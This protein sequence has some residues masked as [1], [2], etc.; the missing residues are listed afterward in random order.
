M[1][2]LTEIIQKRFDGFLHTNSLWKNNTFYGLKQFHLKQKYIKFN[3][4]INEKLRL[5]KYVERFVSYQLEQDNSIEIIAENVQIQKEKRTLGEI[6][7]ILL[8]HKKPIHLEIVYKFYLY[9]DSIGITEVDHFIGPNRKDTLLEKLQKLKTKQLPLLF[10]KACE[11]YLESLAIDSSLITQEVY[12]KAQIFIPF[13]KKHLKLK[14]L[15]G[16]CISGFYIHQKELTLFVDCKFYIPIKKDW[17]LQPHTNV[18]WLNY[19]TFL[20]ECTVYMNRNFSPM[21]WIKS[22]KGELHKYFVVWW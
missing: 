1:S 18:N 19:D 21:V 20:S 8:K 5:G 7:C 2:Q 15:N 4:A 3:T 16:D 14:T 12:F 17:L 10:S 11:S 22:S 6:D 9:D 13:N